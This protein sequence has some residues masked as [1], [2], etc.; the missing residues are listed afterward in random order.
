MSCNELLE[1]IQPIGIVKSPGFN[2]THVGRIGTPTGCHQKLEYA[3][4]G[5]YFCSGCGRVT[6]LFCSVD[7]G[8]LSAAAAK[9]SFLSVNS[10]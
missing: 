8:D 6:Q 10:L 1:V 3:A 9:Q 5:V 7:S 2:Q 4:E